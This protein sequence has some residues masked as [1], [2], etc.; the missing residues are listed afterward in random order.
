MRPMTTPI[1]GI[2]APKVR[3][4]TEIGQRVGKV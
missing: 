4:S 1:V 3:N 2:G